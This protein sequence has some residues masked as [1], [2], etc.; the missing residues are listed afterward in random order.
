MLALVNPT[1]FGTASRV[2]RLAVDMGRYMEIPDLWRL[3]L[4]A[5]LSQLG[6]AALSPALLEKAARGEALTPA[7]A[8]SYANHPAIGRDLVSNIPRLQEVAEIIGLQHARY[9]LEP[10]QSGPSGEAIPLPARILKAAL[11]FEALETR[12]SRHGD[13]APSQVH[14]L[15]AMKERAGWYDPT[16]LEALDSMVGFPVD[17]TLAHLKTAELKPGMVLDETV[18]PGSDLPDFDKGMELSRPAIQR[19]RAAVE[20]GRLKEPL[21][22]L[23]PP[24]SRL[25]FHQL[26]DA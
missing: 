20:E 1:A 16:V 24:E 12:F 3:D 8:A 5:M 9:A 18:S 22:V 19:L 13:D 10:G 4:A 2:R 15:N 25:L 17:H 11:D 14:A 7:E 23:V 26:M 6:C 21:R